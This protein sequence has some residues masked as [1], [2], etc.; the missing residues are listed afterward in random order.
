MFDLIGNVSY[1]ARLALHAV[2]SPDLAEDEI[3]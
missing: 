2:S 3:R 1:R